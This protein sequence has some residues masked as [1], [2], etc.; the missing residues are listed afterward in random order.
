MEG[1]RRCS[2]A[3]FSVS[4]QTADSDVSRSLWRGSILGIHMDDS[5]RMTGDFDFVELRVGT[6]DDQVTG[7]NQVSGGSIDADH[8]TACLAGDGI[9]RQAVSIINIID[10]DLLVLD[11]VGGTH[12]IQVNRDTSF[13]MKLGIGDS[14][15]MDFRL[16][17]R[18]LH[19]ASLMLNCEGLGKRS[20]VL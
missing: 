15:P 1:G 4:H 5:W 20:P 11:D 8:S 18:S 7:R 13:V 19:L 16:Q 3:A 12:Q 6:D 9:S 2:V 10:L 17:E 14:R